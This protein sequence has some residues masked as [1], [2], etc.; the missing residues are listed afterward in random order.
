VCLTQALSVLRQAGAYP[1]GTPRVVISHSLGSLLA[2]VSH[3]GLGWYVYQG[4]NA[5]VYLAEGAK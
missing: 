2:L 5:F 4:P 3:I 1:S